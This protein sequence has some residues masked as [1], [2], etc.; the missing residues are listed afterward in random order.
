MHYEQ[1]KAISA[2]GVNEAVVETADGVKV[3]VFSN[4]MADM[5]NFVEFLTGNYKAIY[6]TTCD[7]FFPYPALTPR[8]TWTDNTQPPT[9]PTNLKYTNGKLTWNASLP[10][11]AAPALAGEYILYNVYVVNKY[12]GLSERFMELV[13][14]TSDRRKSAQGSNP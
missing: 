1:A 7:E 9:V 6:T 11:K 12:G 4:G 3:K 13:L 10:Q 5:K 8:M 14:K 2:K